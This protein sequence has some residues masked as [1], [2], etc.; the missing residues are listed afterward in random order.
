MKLIIPFACCRVRS[1][2]SVLFL[3]VCLCSFNCLL[4]VRWLVCYAR[5]FVAL[6]ERTI[7]C[8][9]FKL[10]LCLSCFCWAQNASVL[11]LASV[12]IR[13]Q[14]GTKL[15]SSSPTV[16][17][18]SL[19]LL[20]ASRTNKQQATSSEQQQAAAAAASKRVGRSHQE[21]M[22]SKKSVV[23]IAARAVFKQSQLPFASAS[24]SFSTF[25]C[26]TTGEKRR[27]KEKH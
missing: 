11:F 20:L 7:D 21:R 2:A 10:S 17:S 23:P 19:F 8:I 12:Q 22:M 27:K 18:F 15:T 14:L 26:A 4:C 9:R 6:R 1:L 16:A 3:S 13:I 25:V 24:A 5:A